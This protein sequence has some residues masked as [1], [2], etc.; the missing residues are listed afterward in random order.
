VV[1]AAVELLLHPVSVR[2]PATA[3]TTATA[4]AEEVARR[5]VMRVI[6]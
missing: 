5:F 2:S 1:D 4:T 6:V 3:T